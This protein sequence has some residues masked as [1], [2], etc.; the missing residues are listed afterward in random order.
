MLLGFDFTVHVVPGVSHFWCPDLVQF[1]ITDR[2]H[3]MSV[4]S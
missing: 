4:C 1:L 3:R 2:V